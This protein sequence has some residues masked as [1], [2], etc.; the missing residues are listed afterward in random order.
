MATKTKEV[1]VGD[2]APDFSAQDETGRSWSLK[3]LKGKTVILYFYPRDNTP[4]CTTEACDFRDRYDAFAKKKVPIFGVSAD[5]A[6]SHAGS[7][8]STACRSRCSS[9][10]TRRS[11]AR[12]ASGSPRLC[13]AA[14]SWGSSARR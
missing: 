12:T 1:G 5:S 10:R 4:G 6:K 7:R 8:P 11:A 13:T 9:T 14:S 2:K 3:A